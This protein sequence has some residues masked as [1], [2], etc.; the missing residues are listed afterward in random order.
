MRRGA[1][2]KVRES[3]LPTLFY[4]LL[5]RHRYFDV[6]WWNLYGYADENLIFSY[7]RAGARTWYLI[8]NLLSSYKS[9]N[10]RLAQSVNRNTI[11]H[12]VEGSNLLRT[13]FVFK[14]LSSCF[15]GI[16][17]I[18]AISDEMSGHWHVTTRGISWLQPGYKYGVSILATI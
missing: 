8:Y 1:R 7:F 13:K 14:N 16:T 15:F 11:N 3:P 12:E 18:L 9:Y 6:V 4:N 10:T 5:T 2:A 17:S